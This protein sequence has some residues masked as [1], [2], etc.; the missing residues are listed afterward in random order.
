ME[1]FARSWIKTRRNLSTAWLLLE[2]SSR[3]NFNHHSPFRSISW[4]FTTDHKLMKNRTFPLLT[5]INPCLLI[6]RAAFSRTVQKPL[7]PY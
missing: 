5:S 2:G 7:A 4:I 6:Y 3:N 1:T